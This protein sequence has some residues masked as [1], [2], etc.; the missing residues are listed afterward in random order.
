MPT[1]PEI[2]AQNPFDAIEKAAINAS[3]EGK[4]LVIIKK[5]NKLEIPEIPTNSPNFREREN[6][7]EYRFIYTLFSWWPICGVVARLSSPNKVEHDCS[8]YEISQIAAD[9]YIAFIEES[10]RLNKLANKHFNKARN[11]AGK[12]KGD[13]AREI[14]GER[15]K[16]SYKMEDCAHKWLAWKKELL[17]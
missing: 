7:A 14:G 15:M 9:A 5:Q 11:L 16:C 10:Y 12:V 4:G 1:K 13:R 2:P 6:I 17:R 3:Y 8:V